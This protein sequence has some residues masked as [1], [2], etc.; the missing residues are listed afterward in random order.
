MPPR[1]KIR[2]NARGLI[3]VSDVHQKSISRRIPLISQLL[4]LASRHL[5]S[6]IDFNHQ[7]ET[8]TLRNLLRVR[9]PVSEN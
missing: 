7:E 3:I 1:Q 9:N 4:Q 5:Q 6:F 8:P 2:H